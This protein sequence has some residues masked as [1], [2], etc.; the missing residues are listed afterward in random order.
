MST[1]YIHVA[2]TTCT[3]TYT[4]TTLDP[5]A[6]I[7]P[8]E[9][10]RTPARLCL[11]IAE[12]VGRDFLAVPT[13]FWAEGN[14]RREEGPGCVNRRLAGQGCMTPVLVPGSSMAA[15]LIRPWP[16]AP[17]A[18]YPLRVESAWPAHPVPFGN[19]ISGHQLVPHCERMLGQGL[20]PRLYLPHSPPS[21]LIIA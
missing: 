10:S 14:G 20:S 2:Y 16:G 21:P 18:R 1:H 4:H 12:C 7:F 19:E 3:H 13:N 11:H 8:L 17:S 15:N 6:S 5:V 9:H